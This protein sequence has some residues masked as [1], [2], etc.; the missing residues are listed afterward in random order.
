MNPFPPG[1]G[2]PG[3]LQK[4]KKPAMQYIHVSSKP[5]SRGSGQV[6][7]SPGVRA[8]PCGTRPLRPL[9]WCCGFG[10]LCLRPCP[11][12]SGGGPGTALPHALTHPHQHP[13]AG[14][15][16][17]S[18]QCG[19]STRRRETIVAV[20]ENI[21]ETQKQVSYNITCLFLNKLLS[22]QW[23]KEDTKCVHN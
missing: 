10:V 11:R 12:S 23:W 18:Q 9:G 14:C 15:L 3:F 20:L 6:C 1:T 2:L 19:G 7:P 22:G 17:T 5:G 8:P 13:Q 16:L 4:Q 21:F